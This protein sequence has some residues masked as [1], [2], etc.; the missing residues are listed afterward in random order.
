M[1]PPRDL[2]DRTAD[3]ALR[4][5]KFCA[6]LPSTWAAQRIA[7]QLFD[8]GTSVGANYRASSR[9][10]SRREFASKIG[11]V[12]EEAD[13][14]QFW[15][16]LLKRS[17]VGGGSDLEDLLAESGE[18]AAIFTTSHKTAME[19]LRKSRRLPIP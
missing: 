9:A 7:G 2:K 11:L 4:I 15:L 13:E 17:G 16:V 12:L 1:S 8:A 19:N 6:S 5:V 3:F 14:S 10:R 18:L